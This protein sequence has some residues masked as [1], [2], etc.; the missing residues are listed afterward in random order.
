MH[1]LIELT[2]GT[3]VFLNLVATEEQNPGFKESMDFPR[4]C[5]G[6]ITIRT[7]REDEIQDGESRVAHEFMA[8]AP[9]E[10]TLKNAVVL[11]EVVEQETE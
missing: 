11:L 7:R 6:N 10:M 3:G 1:L 5:R 2:V 4:T 8:K 9:L